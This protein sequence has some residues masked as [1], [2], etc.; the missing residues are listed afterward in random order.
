[1]LIAS[2]QAQ[3]GTHMNTTTLDRSAITRTVAA[4][5]TLALALVLATAD[6]AS[7]RTD[8]HHPHDVCT[9][10]PQYLPRSADAVEGWL[11]HCSR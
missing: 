7:A 5:T 8:G 10:A 9:L 1:M 4:L 6:P 2:T 3:K 11:R